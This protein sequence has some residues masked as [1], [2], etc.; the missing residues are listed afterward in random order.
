[1]K[2]Y[3]LFILIIAFLF[4]AGCTPKIYDSSTSSSAKQQNSVNPLPSQISAPKED[5][6][7]SKC[8]RSFDNCKNISTQKYDISVSL[9]KIEKFEGKSEADEFYNT[10]KSPLQMGLDNEFMDLNLFD[11]ETG[12]MP[13]LESYFPL[14][15]FASKVRGLKGQTPVV[16]ICDK[17]GNLIKQSKQQLGCG[18][19]LKEIYIPNTQLLSF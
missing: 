7:I 14:V 5:T 11:Y 18:W 16:L 13:P 15:L 12:E 10:W 4:L 9:I 17:G 8:Q 19:D 3:V 1:M 6:L 2:K